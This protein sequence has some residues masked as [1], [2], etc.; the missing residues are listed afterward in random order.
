MKILLIYLIGYSKSFSQSECLKQAKH[1]F[2]HK[3]DYE[4]CKIILWI[5]VPSFGLTYKHCLF[6]LGLEG[7]RTGAISTDQILLRKHF[8]LVFNCFLIPGLVFVIFVFSMEL[9]INIR[10]SQKLLLPGFEPGPSGIWLQL[11]CQL[12][13][14]HWPSWL[15]NWNVPPQKK[16]N[17]VSPAWTLNLGKQ[18]QQT[19]E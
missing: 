14:N 19:L 18:A 13:H 16:D 3:F 1:D 17:D 15:Q 7:L 6:W 10:S 11:L 9:K 8:S 4:L 12:W 5:S 2:M